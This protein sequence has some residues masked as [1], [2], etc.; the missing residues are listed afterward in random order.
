MEST[1]IDSNGVLL[2]LSEN[3]GASVPALRLL[4]TIIAGYPIALIHRYYLFGKP[5]AIQHVFFVL[6]GF[7]LGWCNFGYD[8][9]H[10]TA[11]ILLVYIILKTIGGTIHSVILT[12]SL[13]MAYLLTG[14]YFTGTESYDIVW[15]MPHCILVL[16]LSGLAFDLYDGSLPEEQL[17]KDSKKVALREVPSLLEIGGY[18]YFPT[19]FLVGP[20]FPMQR[21][22]DFVAGKFTEIGE[23]LPQCIIPALRRGSYGFIYLFIYTYGSSIYSDEYILGDEYSA[24]PVIQRLVE[25]GIWGHIVLYKYLSCWLICEGSCI[26]IGLTHNGKDEFGI[27]KWDGCAN[28]NIQLFE[29][30]QNFSHDYIES[31]NINTNLWVFQYIYKR[32]KFLGNKYLSQIGVLLFLSVWHGFHSGYY[33]CFGSEFFVVAM[34]KDLEQILAKNKKFLEFINQPFICNI[35]WIILKIYTLVFMGPCIA[36]LAVLSFSKWWHIYKN[37][38][39]IPFLFWFLWPLYRPFV[40]KLLPPERAHRE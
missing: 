13:N 40:V 2:Y 34:E 35:K 29:L 30:A 36:P 27:T 9:L 8:M 26:L 37:I 12:L 4:L 15:T 5:P 39:F 6:S 21:Y 33:M 22:K 10:T 20:Q 31:F 23:R 28:V 1:N 11:N 3:V 18:V 7:C 17:S 14:Y 19:S 25:L 38:Y 32:L 24:K 16:R